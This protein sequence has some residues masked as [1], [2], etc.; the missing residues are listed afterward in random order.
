MKNKH[1]SQPKA[2]SAKRVASVALINVILI[3][4]TRETPHC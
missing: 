3:I 1:V 2:I 4:S